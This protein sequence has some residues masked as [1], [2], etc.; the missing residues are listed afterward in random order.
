MANLQAKQFELVQPAMK[1]PSRRRVKKTT[2]E[3]K[4]GKG[5]LPCSPNAV[6]MPTEKVKQSESPGVQNRA[7]LYRGKRVKEVV[8]KMKYSHPQKCPG[9]PGPE[10]HGNWHWN[11]TFNWSN[12]NEFLIVFWI[13]VES[14]W[15][16]Y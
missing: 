10:K 7:R 11:S 13:T 15:Y 12:F 6:M 5:K 8:H 1:P 9:R 3:Q 14:N 2:K 16:W 4:Y